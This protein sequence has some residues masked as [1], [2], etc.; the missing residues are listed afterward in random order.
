LILSIIT[1]AEIIE[2]A[3]IKINYEF[4]QI[5]DIFNIWQIEPKQIETIEIP[6]EL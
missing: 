1:P 6:D 4:R 5:N 3:K 2:F